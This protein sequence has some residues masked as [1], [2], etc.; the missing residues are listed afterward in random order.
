MTDQMTLVAESVVVGLLC[1]LIAWLV[2]RGVRRHRAGVLRDRFGPEYVAAREQ[3]GRHSDKELQER[4]D[5]VGKL[6][7]HALTHEEKERFESTW[8][9]A[10]TRFVDDPSLAVAEADRLVNDVMQTRGYP[11]AD[12]DRRA[13]DISVEHPLV[14]RDYRAAHAIA[15]KNKERQATTEELREA[16]VHYRALFQDLVSVAA[17]ALQEVRS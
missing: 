14:V 16:M 6:R 7:L 5:R 8:H 4:V 12:F 13:A 1:L 9:V 15:R 11:M 3:Y 17:P 10:Q 2:W